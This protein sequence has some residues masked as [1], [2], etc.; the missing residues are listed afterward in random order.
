MLANG[1]SSRVK[2]PEHLWIKRPNHHPAYMTQEQQDEIK[3]TLRNNDF[4]HRFRTGRGAALT[5]GLLRC[6]VCKRSHSV[7]YQRVKS[8][9]YSCGWN[10]EPCTQFI[11]R[12]FDE[13][14]LTEVFKILKTPPLEMLKLALQE[15]RSH[16]R[17]RLKWIESERERFEHEERRARERAELTHGSLRRVNRDALEKLENLFKEKEEFE[18][19]ITLDQS[20]PKHNE[21]EDE[22]EELCKLVSDVPGLWHNPLVTHKERKEILRTV[23]DHI[24][25]AATRERIDATIFWKSGS[26]T[27]FSI[28]RSLG[29]YI[30]IRELHAKKLTVVE[31]KEH[32]AAGKSS[33]GQVVNVNE[34]TLYKIL[35]KLGLKPNRYSVDYLFLRQK[36]AELNREGRSFEWI[37]RYFNEQGMASAS[38][39]LWTR[40]MV[41]GLNVATR[42]RTESL[43]NLHRTAITEAQAQGLSYREMALQFNERKIRRRNDRPWT[44]LMVANKAKRL[45][46]RKR[47]PVLQQST[48]KEL[49]EPAVRR[50]LA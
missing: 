22:L 34:N 42:E 12:E 2:V 50:R 35:G 46:R 28:W 3:I 38:G 27:P 40:N 39:K 36:A 44:W 4:L 16:E 29:R 6:A 24:V 1:C 10:I 15:T 31:I 41:Y 21:S 9:G 19:K 13:R 5:Q 43:D 26:Q 33:T 20:V 30:L 11:N 49:S 48:S 37:A 25:V 18:Q 14:I 47:N 45:N 17:S 32:L 23:I 7:S 8:Y